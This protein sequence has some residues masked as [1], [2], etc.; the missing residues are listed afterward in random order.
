MKPLSSPVLKRRVLH[1]SSV[2]Y[3]VA[4]ALA[5]LPCVQAG[6]HGGLG[7]PVGGLITVLAPST[8]GQVHTSVVADAAGDF[9]VI[10]G[11]FDQDGSASGYGIYAQ[12]YRSDGAPLGS[13]FRV[14]TD[15]RREQGN[16]AVAMDVAGGFVVAWDSFDQA[17]ST[18]G[19]DIYA[20]RYGSDGAP[21]G[22]NFLVSADTGD[23]QDHP[24]VAM[25]AEGD[26]VVVWEAF[27]QAGSGSD[28]DI[29]A[30][31]YRSDGAPLGSNFLVNTVTSSDQNYP[32]VA[33][34]AAGSF[35]VAWQSFDQAGP[36]SKYDV[37]AQRYG[38]N[39]SPLGSNF[40]VNTYTSSYQDS[41]VVAMD[42]TGSFV[43]AWQSLGQIGPTSRY[44]IY[45]QRYASNGAPLGSNF[46]V[47]THTSG[48]QKQSAV[49]MDA[50]GEFVVAWESYGQIANHY[51]DVYAQLYSA[52]GAAL[53]SNFLVPGLTPTA[54][55]ATYV[56]SGAPSV[57]M[58]AVGDFVIAQ[59]G[60]YV[61][62]SGSHTYHFTDSTVQR[63]QGESV[64]S[65]GVAVTG[66]SSDDTVIP[67]S[68]FSVS[69]EVVNQAAP[70][71]ETADADLNSFIR[72]AMDPAT[73][74]P[75]TCTYTGLVGARQYSPPHLVGL[76]APDAPGTIVYGA[77][78]PGSNRPP[79]TGSVTVANP[80][81]SDSACWCSRRVD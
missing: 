50:A 21:L 40:L 47:N 8:N 23:N 28:Y 78:V 24:V 55:S 76:M 14:N 4:L 79:F 66:V 12:R 54:S 5:T 11:A 74:V 69:F 75:L 34:D 59:E 46:L 30:Q 13:A 7:S 57:A 31:R 70:S 65:P 45:A 20:Q 62:D 68:P 39:G 77:T 26:F 3:A 58:D 49:A 41:P 38:S 2:A 51:S 9:V 27:D 52:S 10:W 80:P 71:F 19:Y 32:V 33:M 16:P 15:T 56:A 64:S 18:S 48:N 25:D 81:N 60:Y 37:Y 43:V 61:T 29:Y 17:G 42:A 53:G 36:T 72:T 6:A 22:S 67:G 73:T 44:D 63:Y 1:S 35:V